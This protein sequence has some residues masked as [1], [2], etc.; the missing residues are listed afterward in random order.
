MSVGTEQ[1]GHDG[2][3][4]SCAFKDER[5]APKQRLQMSSCLCG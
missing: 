5:L 2:R 3:S 4:M 1:T